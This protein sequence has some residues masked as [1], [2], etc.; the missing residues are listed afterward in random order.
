MKYF[1]TVR[2]WNI[3]YKSKVSFSTL[4]RKIIGFQKESIKLEI[5]QNIKFIDTREREREK[6]NILI[7]IR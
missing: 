4:Y 1:I 6:I 3:A 7:T 2:Y 5:I